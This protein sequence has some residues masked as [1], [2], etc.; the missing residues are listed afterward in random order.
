MDAAVHGVIDAQC[1]MVSYGF[2]ERERP[3]KTCH[4]DTARTKRRTGVSKIG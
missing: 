4:R 2:Y 3:G 1:S